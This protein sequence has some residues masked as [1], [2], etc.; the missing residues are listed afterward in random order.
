VKRFHANSNCELFDQSTQFEHPV[1]VVEEPKK[2]F[3]LLDRIG[4]DKMAPHLF[5]LLF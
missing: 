1:K 3:F 5:T 4:V 2:E